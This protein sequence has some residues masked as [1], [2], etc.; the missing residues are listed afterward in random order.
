MKALCV[1]QPWA[2]LIAE[3]KKTIE[4]R[5]WLTKYRGPLVIVSSKTPDYDALAHF[6]IKKEDCLYGVAVCVSNLVDCREMNFSDETS[7]C[8]DVYD[9]AFS[10]FLEDVKPIAPLSIKGQLGLFDVAVGDC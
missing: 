9:G 7:A 5:T 10:W 8:C 2:K 3:G 6:G 1:K 4:T